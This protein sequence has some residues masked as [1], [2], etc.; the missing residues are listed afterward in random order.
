[1]IHKINKIIISTSD[2]ENKR[3]KGFDKEPKFRC[4]H[5]I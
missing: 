1:M 3:G 2:K 5:M 4:L